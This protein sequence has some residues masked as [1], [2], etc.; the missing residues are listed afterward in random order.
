MINDPVPRSAARQPR[1]I[2]LINGQPAGGLLE[3]QVDAN[4]TSQADTMSVRLSTHQMGADWWSRVQAADMD[5]FVGFP[6]DSTRYS[7]DDLTRIVSGRLD[8]IQL[9]ML[10]NEVQIVG[11]DLTAALIDTK[12]VLQ[13]TNKSSSYIAESFAREHGLTPK[14]TQTQRPTGA[15]YRDLRVSLINAKSQWDVLAFLAE[16]EGFEVFVRGRELHFRP[17]EEIEKAEPFV[18]AWHPPKGERSHPISNAM[19]VNFR[20]NLTLARTIRVVGIVA[21]SKSRFEVYAQRERV[22][23]QVISPKLR[24]QAP[25]QQYVYSLP[26][27]PRDEAQKWVNSKLLELSRHEMILTAVLPGDM[28]L[29][30]RTPILV[31]GTGTAFDQVYLPNSLVHSYSVEDGYTMRVDCRNHPPESQAVI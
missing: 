7:T 26:A 17:K 8:D 30:S 23:N 5:V 9:D 12:A 15:Y 19:T 11:R 21:S 27:M 14:V 10:S 24:L 29:T 16:R 6:R 18:I 31:T 28:R 13:F 25:P 20:R 1:A 4:S 22:F 3:F 2:V